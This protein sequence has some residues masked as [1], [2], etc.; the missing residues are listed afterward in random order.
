[1][2]IS[3]EWGTKIINIPRA[4]LTLVQSSPTEIRE[5]SLNFFRLTL[6]DLESA[7][8]GMPH[9]RTHN[10]NTEVLLGGIVYARV[11]EIINDYTVT[12]EDGQYAVNLVGANSNVGDVVNVNQVSIRSQNSAGLISNQAIE[13]SSFNGGVT[14]DQ[15]NST[16]RASSGTVFPIG[17]PQVPVDNLTDLHLIAA[18]RG[19]NK[20]LVLGNLLLDNTASW[21]GHEFVGES[22]IKSV[23]TI[24][25]LADVINCEFYDCN[26]TG[27]LDGN[28]Q[29]ERS[30]INA[31]NFV[32]GFIFRCAIGP[33]TITLGTAG[34]AN[35]FS[36]YS[37]V[38]GT[39]TPTI[40]MNGDGQLA[41][42]DYNGGMLLT[43]Y[44]DVGSHS[45][46]L[47]SG[48]IKLDSTITSGTFVVRGTGK[49]VD[50]SGNHIHSGTWN[51]G[52]TI[53]NELINVTEI[54]EAVWDVQT[55]DHIL[56][57]ST[58]EAIG[59]AGDPWGTLVAGNTDP[60]TFGAL[61]KKSLTLG[62]YLGLK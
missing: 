31:L 62:K 28:S 33:S 4:D 30:V 47:V 45:I 23:I 5:L 52:V 16:G 37:T 29:I 40:D 25:A 57:G 12:F 9:I 36:C 61:V 26:V 11:I 59:N 19:F 58:G 20:I 13:F 1:M 38:P 35:M 15:N 27:T 14:I 10:H 6:K 24:P 39:S 54:K 50:T 21:T 48:Q 56:A 18:R 44:N 53:I 51:G 32:D 49:L 7:E 22:A 2:A 17:T 42:R 46:D 43:N 55:S 41:L 34:I 60:D 3:V 8:L